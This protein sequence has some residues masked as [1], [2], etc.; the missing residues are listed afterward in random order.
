MPAYLM[1]VV[2]NSDSLQRKVDVANA[3]VYIE[4]PVFYASEIVSHFFLSAVSR[5]GG[6]W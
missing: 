3:P 2:P 6:S 1:L 5:Y 4:K